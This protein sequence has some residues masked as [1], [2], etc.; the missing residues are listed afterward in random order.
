MEENILRRSKRL[1]RY[2][3]C[4]HMNKYECPEKI[5]KFLSFE[6]LCKTLENQTIRLSKP[7]D[8][9]D[10]LDMYLQA[11][12]GKY[13]E[14][15]LVD[16]RAKFLDFVLSDMDFSSLPDSQF[17]TRVML[18]GSD[19]K[20][21]LPEQKEFLQK[22]MLNTPIENL[23]D[24]KRLEQTGQDIISFVQSSFEIDGVFCSTTNFRNLLMW[25]HYADRHRGA[26]LEFTPNREKYSVLLASKKITYSDKRPLLYE[27]AKDMVIQSLAMSIEESVRAIM[28]KLIFT[29]SC[30]WEYEQ[31]YRLFVPFCIERSKSFT[32]LRYQ[33]KELSSI[34]LGCRMNKQNRAKIINLAKAINPCVII[35]E[36]LAMPREFSLG[37][38]KIS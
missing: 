5:Y 38:E 7:S 18:I 33:S 27:T 32:T 28:D 2:S 24:L 4:D 23:Y 9:N 17:K 19:L 11:A 10:P 15:F 29:K 30:D 14:A 1:E 12:F 16:L 3:L 21:A 37:F 8:L 26:V 13:T 25:A 31:E 34:F 36:A 6:G 22:E 20:Q 35:Y